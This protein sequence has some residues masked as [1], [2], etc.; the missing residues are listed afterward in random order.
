MA[1]S[2]PFQTLKA[3][4]VDGKN[5]P[6]G[7]FVPLDPDLNSAVTAL[8]AGMEDKHIKAASITGTSL[9]SNSIT[10]HKIDPV[11]FRLLVFTGVDASGAPDVATVTG[12]KAGDVVIGIVNLTDATSATANFGPT[13]L[14][15]NTL[16]QLSADLSV[17]S[18]VV[19]LLSKG[20]P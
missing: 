17:K 20:T 3:F 18:L 6:A 16:P 11:A 9:A 13:S 15:N 2:I 5:Q 19:L 12:A 1:Q 8:V 7:A 4:L 14:N 10:A